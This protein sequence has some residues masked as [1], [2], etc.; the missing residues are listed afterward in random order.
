MDSA[1]ARLLFIP[2]IG[3]TFVVV[4]PTA[5]GTAPTIHREMAVIVDVS[6][7]RHSYTCVLEMFGRLYETSADSN[8]DVRVAFAASSNAIGVDGPIPA[9]SHQRRLAKRLNDAGERETAS[10]F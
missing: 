9:C 10:V 1:I 3:D 6:A 8:A 2:S 4:V 5:Q 7:T